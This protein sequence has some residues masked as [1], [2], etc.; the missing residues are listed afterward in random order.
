VK[1][2]RVRSVIKSINWRVVAVMNSFAVS[3]LFLDGFVAFKAAML[4]NVT[5]LFLYYVF[6]RVWNCIPWGRYVEN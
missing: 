6:E 5:G 3:L 2:T 4:M 1:E